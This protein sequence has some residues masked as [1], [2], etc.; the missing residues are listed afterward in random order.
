MFQTRTSKHG[1]D[2]FENDPWGEGSPTVFPWLVV[3]LVPGANT[4]SSF[5]EL[6]VG[7][8]DDGSDGDGG[9]RDDGGGDDGVDGDDDDDDGGDGGGDSRGCEDNADDCDDV[10]N[11]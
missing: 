4:V 11:W 10:S 7:D 3:V 1:H 8:C 5:L 6:V 2:D 9:D